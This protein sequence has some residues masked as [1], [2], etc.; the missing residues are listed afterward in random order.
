MSAPL[1]VVGVHFDSLFFFPSVKVSIF[2][3][4]TGCPRNFDLLFIEL[5]PKLYGNVRETINEASRQFSF[6][7]IMKFNITHLI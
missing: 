2:L 7:E 6:A 1:A 5:S 4:E 3:L